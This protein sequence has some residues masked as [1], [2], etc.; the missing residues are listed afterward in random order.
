MMNA[1]NVLYARSN[2]KVVHYT[3]VGYSGR[4]NYLIS[5]HKGNYTV[6]ESIYG[7]VP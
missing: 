5:V 7:L 6:V 4:D 1:L 3:S 2:Q